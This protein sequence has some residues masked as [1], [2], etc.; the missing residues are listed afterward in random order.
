LTATEAVFTIDNLVNTTIGGMQLYFAEGSPE[1]YKTVLNTTLTITP[2]FKAVTPNV[3]AAGGTLVKVASPGI[4][5][6][7][8]VT[9]GFA[10]GTKV[11]NRTIVNA[12]NEFYCLT[13]QFVESSQM[14][15]IETVVGGADTA[16]TCVATDPASCL[17]D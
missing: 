11:C 9:L 10:N 13:N 5:A 2:K 7:S 12:T 16:H 6:G 17:L 15:V 1:G 3:G 8:A 14:A 4:G